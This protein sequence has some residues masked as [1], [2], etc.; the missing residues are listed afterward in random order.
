MWMWPIGEKVDR[1]L[2]RLVV[3]QGAAALPALH[4]AFFGAALL[5]QGAA[6]LPAL[7]TAFF[8]VDRWFQGVATLPAL[9]VAIFGVTSP[10]TLGAEIVLLVPLAGEVHPVRPPAPDWRLLNP[11]LSRMAWSRAAV[12][13]IP[14]SL[15]SSVASAAELPPAALTKSLPAA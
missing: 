15:R 10:S 8:G 3:V 7:L 14:P 2:P 11:I 5:F 6:T 13:S 4:T 9:L 12:P 1:L